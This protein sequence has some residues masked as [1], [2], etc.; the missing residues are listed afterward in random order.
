[1]GHGYGCAPRGPFPLEWAARLYRSLA[2]L[3]EQCVLI[4]PRSRSRARARS[5]SCAAL[6]RHLAHSHGHVL[7]FR[8]ILLTPLGMGANKTGAR[9]N[10]QRAGIAQL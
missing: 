10:A 8:A 6:S 3:M 7:H 5:R 1:M 9:A 4:L 2:L